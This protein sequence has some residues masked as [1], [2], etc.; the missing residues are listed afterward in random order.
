MKYL[1]V[2][3]SLLICLSFINAE[4]NPVCI[5]TC[6]RRKL[7]PEKF[8]EVFNKCRTDLTC[9]REAVQTEYEGCKTECEGKEEVKFDFVTC[10]KDCIIRRLG[11][12]RWAEIFL[13]CQTDVR[14]YI[15]EAGASGLLCA[16]ECIQDKKEEKKEEQDPRC[17]MICLARKLSREKFREV[18]NKCRLDLTCW[19]ESVQTEYDQCK[20]ECEGDKLDFITCV[21][22]CIIRRL[23]PER[24]AEI[25]LKCQTDVR[26]YIR[27]AGASGLLCAAECIQDKKEEKKE[28]KLDFVGCLK[29]CITKKL[30]PGRWA[31]IFEKCKTDVRCY[32]RE[33]GSAGLACAAECIQEQDAEE[34]CSSKV[35][36]VRNNYK[37]LDENQKIAFEKII[38]DKLREK[39]PDAPS[40]YVTYFVHF[41]L[42]KTEYNERKV[43]AFYKILFETE[44]CRICGCALKCL[45]SGWNF[46]KVAALVA[47][48]KVSVPCYAATVGAQAAQCIAKC[49]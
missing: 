6:L 9:W 44:K 2:L 10:V 20:S 12:E 49:L 27:E 33:A 11:P 47:R 41:L 14:C 46:I 38:E 16:A 19:R 13:K 39:H 40:L 32:I 42:K 26:C 48:C 22:D 29:E 34:D 36:E 35:V 25:F 4:Q 31:E 30:G 7:T 17:L 28:E 24:W 15:R 23:G 37:N 18:Y 45:G 43:C 21:K 3:L 8:R 1:F 5:L